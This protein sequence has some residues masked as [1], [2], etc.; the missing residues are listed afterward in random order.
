MH[1]LTAIYDDILSHVRRDLVYSTN[2][3]TNVTL[4]VR[5]CIYICDHGLIST[6]IPLRHQAETAAVAA[7]MNSLR[8]MFG[9]DAVPEPSSQLVTR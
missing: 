3:R 7:T 2:M 8:A 9:E 1:A 4:H 6:D 5:V